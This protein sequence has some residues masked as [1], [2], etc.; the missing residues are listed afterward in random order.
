[1]RAV[2]AVSMA[3]ETAEAKGRELTFTT[4]GALGDRIAEELGRDADAA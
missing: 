1:M 4:L 3:A 2:R